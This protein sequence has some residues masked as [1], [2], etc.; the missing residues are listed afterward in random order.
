MR[1]GA[2]M[3]GGKIG[4]LDCY[5]ATASWSHHA[6]WDTCISAQFSWGRPRQQSLAY[7]TGLGF[8]CYLGWCGWHARVC[9]LSR[10]INSCHCQL[11]SCGDSSPDRFKVDSIQQG[12]CESA[13]CI[14]VL[15]RAGWP[16]P[17]FHVSGSVHA[18]RVRG[19]A[20]NRCLLGGAE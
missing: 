3:A 1:A 11:G 8:W 7:T 13:T 12:H 18:V 9:L 5:E 15:P 17:G 10:G 14:P 4:P 19:A 16:T 6:P 2:R 20:V